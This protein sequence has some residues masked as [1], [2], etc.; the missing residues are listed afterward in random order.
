MLAILE[1]VARK[2]LPEKRTLK[3]RLDGGER[4]RQRDI[5]KHSRQ[6]DSRYKGPEAGTHSPVQK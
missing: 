3:S 6:G 1:S 2:G 5:R 4:A